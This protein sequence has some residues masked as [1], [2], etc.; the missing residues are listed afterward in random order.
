MATK[1]I[2]THV[3]EQAMDKITRE[4]GPAFAMMGPRIQRAIMAE[5][6]MIIAAS[7]PEGMVTDEMARRIVKEGWAWASKESGYV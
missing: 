5:A 7:W 3:A 2:G 1:T 6:V 4:W